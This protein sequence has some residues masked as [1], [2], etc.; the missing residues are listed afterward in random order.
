MENEIL[1]A[2]NELRDDLPSTVDLS[3]VERKL[4]N[5]LK[6]LKTIKSIVEE[7]QSNQ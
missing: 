4:D 6:Q 3:G 1:D 2:I 5:I 7:L